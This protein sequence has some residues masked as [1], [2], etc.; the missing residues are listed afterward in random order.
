MNFNYLDRYLLESIQVKS[1]S[2]LELIELTN[3]ETD[4]LMTVLQ[5]LILRGYVKLIDN[6][7]HLGERVSEVNGFDPTSEV[8]FL[9]K[10]IV[11]NRQENQGSFFLSK[12]LLSESEAREAQIM[13]KN[14]NLFL[15]EAH[16]RNRMKKQGRLYYFQNSCLDYQSLVEKTYRYFEGERV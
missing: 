4:Q 2:L 11:Q 5:K 1:R 9:T 3:L 10:T 14:I 12:Y 13:L 6:E 16:S 7:Y 8:L 15:Q